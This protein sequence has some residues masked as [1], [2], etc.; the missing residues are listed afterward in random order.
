VD[1]GPMGRRH[2]KKRSRE[3]AG[4]MKE[5]RTGKDVITG[6]AEKYPL[7]YLDPYRDSQETYRK[8]VLQGA[9]PETKILSHFTLD[10]EDQAE[11]YDTPA[12]PVEVVT[13]AK[14]ADY[15][16]F[17]RGMMAAKKGPLAVVPPTEGASTLSVFNWGRIHAHQAA[18]LKKEQEAGNPVPDWGAEFQRFTANKDNY[19]DLLVVLSRGPYSHVEAGA[20]GQKEDWLRLSDTIRKYHELTHVICRRLY[21][22]Q[23]QPIWDEL[24]ADTVG[25]FAAF[26]ELDIALEKRFLGIREGAYVGGRLENY[27]DHPERLVPEISR[28]LLRLR[29]IT[30]E[31]RDLTPF[32]LI[33]VL[34]ERQ[35]E[36]GKNLI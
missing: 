30:A 18:F 11:L 8:V 7:L 26:G 24:C 22:D 15:E 6:L 23:V 36:L 34:E 10:A 35:A 33:P 29:D 3:G 4:S 13:L 21:P 19:I 14:R 12:G 5:G 20:A 16:T 31:H 9:E 25:L 32:A 27:T 28:V 2:V 1:S 17:V